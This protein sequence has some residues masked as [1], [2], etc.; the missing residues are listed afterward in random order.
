MTSSRQGQ[1][2]LIVSSGQPGASSRPWE[3]AVATAQTGTSP[4]PNRAPNAH[5]AA[6]TAATASAHA[7]PAGPGNTG[8]AASARHQPVNTTRTAST[9]P[10]NR[11]NQPRTVSAGRR[12]SAAIRR[13]PEPVALAV[14]ADPI[15]DATSARRPS[16]PT[17]NNTC[18]APQPLQR[19]RRGTSR[20]N[21]PRSRTS[22]ARA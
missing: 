20:T 16:T 14:K 6:V 10:A 13:Y 19:A 18:V 2:V 4:T 5:A 7:D 21:P 17:G 11:R 9:R 22:R 1:L 8:S 15:T 3:I 12:S